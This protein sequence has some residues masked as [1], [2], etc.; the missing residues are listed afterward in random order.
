MFVCDFIIIDSVI[1]SKLQEILTLDLQDK[2]V[3]AI[4]KTFRETTPFLPIQQ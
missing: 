3:I 2:K 4:Y 1:Y